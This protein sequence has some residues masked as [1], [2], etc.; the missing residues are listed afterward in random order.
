MFKYRVKKDCSWIL[1]ND[2]VVGVKREKRRKG[3]KRK[4]RVSSKDYNECGANE[5][6]YVF[7][8]QIALECKSVKGMKIW[9][10][11][12]ENAKGEMRWNLE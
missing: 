6:I 2:E 1:R 5:M 3:Y 9:L 10:E 12:V 11:K 7:T 8:K 4:T